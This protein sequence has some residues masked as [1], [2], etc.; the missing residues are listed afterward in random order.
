M[1]RKASW[2]Q[3]RGA[4]RKGTT[5][6]LSLARPPSPQPPPVCTRASLLQVQL[7]HRNCLRAPGKPSAYWS[8]HHAPHTQTPTPPGAGA[9]L[10]LLDCRLGFF[11]TKEDSWIMTPV[12]RLL[13]QSSSHCPRW[14]RTSHSLPHR[15][16]MLALSSADTGW[17]PSGVTNW[18]PEGQP[19]DIFGRGASVTP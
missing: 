4:E 10:R 6:A 11:P 5:E 13:V 1:V 3:D 19:T 17:K 7:C 12:S 8:L 14:R 18:P 2:K 9:L 15:W 16:Q